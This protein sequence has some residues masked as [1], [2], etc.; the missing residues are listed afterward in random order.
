MRKALEW[1]SRRLRVIL[2]QVEEDKVV[3]IKGSS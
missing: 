2:G 1:W 3:P